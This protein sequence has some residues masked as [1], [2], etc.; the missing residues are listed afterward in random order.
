[1]QAVY[2]PKTTLELKGLSNSKSLPVGASVFCL[3]RAKAEAKRKV[4]L[5][6]GFLDKLDV[7]VNGRSAARLSRDFPAV[8]DT[9]RVE[10]TL[11]AGVND[12]VLRTTKDRG[13]QYSV[14]V[15]S[16]RLL[17]EDGSP[18]RGL[19]LDTFEGVPDA[20]ERWRERRE[21]KKAH[22]ADF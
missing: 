13:I 5:E 4:V 20:P 11:S 18:A 7:T 19:T 9:E 2:R 12:I 14:W 6:V 10:L 17:E 21:T 1:L 15:L 16:I 3:V 8:W 22:V